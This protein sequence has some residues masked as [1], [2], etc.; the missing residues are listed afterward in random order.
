MARYGGWTMRKLTVAYCEF[1]GSSRGARE[2]V[3]TMLPAFKQK[4][5]QYEVATEIRKGKHPYVRGDYVKGIPR[6]VGVKNLPV[7]EIEFHVKNLRRHT[8]DKATH[9]KKRVLTKTP[10]IQGKWTIDTFPQT[11]LN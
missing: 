6:I 11:G 5:P 4:F 10:S 8:N 7:D 1:S 9:L 2:F 3:E